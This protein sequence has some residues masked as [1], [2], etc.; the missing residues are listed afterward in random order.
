[1]K[2]RLPAIGEVRG[3]G[4]LIG[5][6]LV[7]SRAEK[8]PDYDLAEEVLYRARWIEGCRSR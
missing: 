7:R 3:R 5:I 4:L 2:R 1:M 6:E 8:V